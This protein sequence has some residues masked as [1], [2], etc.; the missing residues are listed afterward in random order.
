[1][2][3]PRILFVTGKLAEPALHR[4]LNELAQRAEFSYSVAVLPISVVAL[5]TTPWIASHLT[6]P[7]GVDRVMIPGLCL[8]NPDVIEERIGKPVD[9]GPQD[10]RELPTYFGIENSTGKVSG[11]YDISILAEIN[12]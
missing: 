12:H 9:Q 6:M 7:D 4:V 3:S 1:M 5:A 10:L 11:K 2:S 8:G